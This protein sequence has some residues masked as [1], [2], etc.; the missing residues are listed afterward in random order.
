L[1][2]HEA[3][4]LLQLATGLDASGVAMREELSAEES[5]AFAGYVDRR[6]SG[7]PL[8]Y[9]EGTVQFGPVEVKVDPR[10]LIPRPETEVL[11]E[12][13]VATLGD[14]DE[15]TVIVDIGTGSGALALALKHAFP[16]AR[17]YATEIDPDAISLAR[18][19]VETA[20][21]TVLAG[22]LFDAL[23]FGMRGNIDLLISNP[24]YVADDDDLPAE[25]GDHEPARALFAGPEGD[26][27]LVRIAEQAF[28]W[29]R[30]GGW[31]FIEIGESQADRA[32][33]LFA[34][35]Q[36][37]V[38]EDLAGRPRILAGYRGAT[39]CIEGNR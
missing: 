5:E 35:F 38:Y 26:E 16:R 3:R 33:E 25:V 15:N 18:E 29:V 24:P 9:I 27:V 30:P 6:V 17:V 11:W 12:R 20:G 8:Q 2:D 23:P 19:N 1:P 34:D 32:M 22:D 4:R 13:S 37:V 28:H 7:E 39:S 10:V 21:I 36:C 14:A 31:L